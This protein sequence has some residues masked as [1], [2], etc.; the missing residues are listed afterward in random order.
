MASAENSKTE[1][2]SS[3][4]TDTSAPDVNTI[5]TAQELPASSEHPLK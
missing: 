4:E 5:R 2:H 1:R 3:G